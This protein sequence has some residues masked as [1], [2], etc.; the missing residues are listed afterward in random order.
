[1]SATD[2]YTYIQCVVVYERSFIAEV[3]NCSIMGC[4]G[5]NPGAVMGVM[6]LFNVLL[7]LN[8]YLLCIMT[9]DIPVCTV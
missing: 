9:A 7:I 1:M 2:S 6:M 4:V 8:Y 5:D 3:L